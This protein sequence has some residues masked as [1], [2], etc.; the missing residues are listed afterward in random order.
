MKTLFFTLLLFLISFIGHAQKET[1]A[2]FYY[3]PYTAISETNLYS[4]PTKK[5]N[6]NIQ[7]LNIKKANVDEELKRALNYHDYRFIAISGNSYI[8]PG[9]EE[10]MIIKGQKAYGILKNN[11][12]Y[13]NKYKFKVVQGT[14]DAIDADS[15]PLQSIA[16]HF[17]ESYNKLLL[18]KLEYIERKKD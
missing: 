6:Y 1:S 17:A 12:P 14:S 3:R 5:F 13:I 11:E 18:Q 2:I 7:Y 8:Y 10:Y 9:L 15:P 4:K 16:E